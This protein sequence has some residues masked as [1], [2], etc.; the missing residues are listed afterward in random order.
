MKNRLPLVFTLA[1][2]LPVFLALLVPGCGNKEPEYQGKTVTVWVA[3]LQDPT[4]E[5]QS[6][7][8]EWLTAESVKDQRVMKALMQGVKTGNYAAAELLGEVAHDAPPAMI[9]EM[10]QVLAETTRNKGSNISVR[11][12]AAKALPKFG[13]AAGPAVPALIDMLKD[14]TNYTLRERAAECIGNLPP[15]LAQQATPALLAAAKTDSIPA[16]Q[17]KAHEVL[18]T[19][20]PEALKRLGGN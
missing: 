10:V 17:F 4:P 16:V 20:D 7:A 9:P 3:A 2:C 12:A 15:N 14:D 6:T 1:I 13:A 5:V 11:L 18:R 19:V 8:R